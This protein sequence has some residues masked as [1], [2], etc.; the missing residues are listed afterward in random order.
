MPLRHCSI[1]PTPKCS[2]TPV[3]TKCSPSHNVRQRVGAGLAQN[4]CLSRHVTG[5][6]LL[7]VGEQS[8]A[9]G[10][11]FRAKVVLDIVEHASGVPLQMLD[12]QVNPILLRVCLRAAQSSL[13]LLECA[14]CLPT[15]GLQ[16]CNTPMFESSYARFM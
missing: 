4:E 2:H 8:L 1:R 13:H 14:L 9:L 7:Q 5:C 12:D 16:K 10:V 15:S 11:K 6:R 3:H